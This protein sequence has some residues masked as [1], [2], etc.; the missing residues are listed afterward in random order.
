[1]LSDTLKS[2]MSLFVNPRV[3][4]IEKHIVKVVRAIKPRSVLTVERNQIADELNLLNNRWA[5]YDIMVGLVKMRREGWIN[6]NEY[7]KLQDAIVGKLG[8]NLAK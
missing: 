6:D 3:E 8:P 2:K 7:I 4:N 5:I 1:M